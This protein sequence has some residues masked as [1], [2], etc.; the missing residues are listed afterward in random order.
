M[1]TC[2]NDDACEM[3]QKD[4]SDSISEDGATL[5]TDQHFGCIHYREKLLNVTE[6][7][8]KVED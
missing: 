6:I 5:Y 4:K 2:S 3:I 1:G 7:K 8:K